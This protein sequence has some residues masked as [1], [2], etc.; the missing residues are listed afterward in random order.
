MRRPPL[1]VARE[2]GL[3]RLPILSANR[4]NRS[5]LPTFSALRGAL[6]DREAR[7]GL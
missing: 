2:E 1:G 3:R 5:K 7:P 4:P 6:R